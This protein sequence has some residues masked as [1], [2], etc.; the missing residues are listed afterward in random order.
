MTGVMGLSSKDQVKVE[1]ERV[2]SFNLDKPNPILM[3][4]C[5]HLANPSTPR[6][7]RMWRPPTTPGR[8]TSSTPMSPASARMRSR[9]SR[10]GSSSSPPRSD[11][12]GPKPYFDTVIFKEVPTSSSRLQLLKGGA[13]DI[14]QLLAPIEMKNLAADPKATVASFDASQMLWI[15]LNTKFKPLDDARVRQAIN[16]AIPRKA[17]LDTVLQGYGAK[18]TAVMPLFY[19]GATNKFWAYDTD[20]AKAKGLLKD[21]GLA[22]GFSTVL[23]YNAGDPIEEPI[24]IMVQTALKEIGVTLDLKKLPAG[25]FFDSLTKRSEPMTFNLDAPWTP[26]PGFSL[27]LY[28]KSTSFVDFSNFSNPE[29]DKLIDASLSTL[30]Q[31][32][33]MTAVTKAQELLMADAPWG[34]IAYPGFQIAHAK[35]L[36][37]LT[38]YTSNRLSFQDYARAG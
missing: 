31:E 13:V 3:I 14:A 9:K 1:G 10:A 24:A 33:R 28:F 36:T 18:Q 16:F 4:V 20:A 30:V 6:S 38:Y 5:G 27:N 21:A 12:Y 11:Y 26:D 17:I 37:N 19:P 22:D 35:D 32:D 7:V 34:F 2:V 29:V 15:E 8:A 25:T 23:A